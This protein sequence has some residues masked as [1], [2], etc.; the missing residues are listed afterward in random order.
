M[1]LKILILIIIVF[2]SG[3]DRINKVLYKDAFEENNVRTAE[4]DTDKSAGKNIAV[5]NSDTAL[6]LIEGLIKI[7]STERS[8]RDCNNP[9]SLYYINDETG[10]LSANYK[11]YFLLKIYTLPHSLL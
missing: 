6:R 9:D 5:E 1:F 2:L 4:Q 10:A 8:F 3:C 11:N 7:N